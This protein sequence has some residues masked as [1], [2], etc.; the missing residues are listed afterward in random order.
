MKGI[1][2]N[3]RCTKDAACIKKEGFDFVIRY[4][5]QTTQQP[6]KVVTPEEAVAIS[7][8]GLQLAVVYEDLANHVGY[9][10]HSEGKKDGYYAYFYAQ[11]LHQPGQSAIYFAVDYDATA[12]EIQG[13]IQ[14][15]FHG[16]QQGF[17]DFSNGQSVYDIGVYGS[18]AACR[19]LRTHLPFVKYSWL[20]ESTR[21]LGS[22]AYSEWNLKQFVTK[23]KLCGLPSGG[24]ERNEANG[25]FGQFS[26]ATT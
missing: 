18:G 15:Y 21:W 8:A 19:W 4:Y 2:T 1:S 7:A 9:F 26:V 12:G 23:Q 13:V 14:D 22:K 25:D 5:S 3:R 10:N 16:V 6:E 24:W 17:K 20:A 11:K